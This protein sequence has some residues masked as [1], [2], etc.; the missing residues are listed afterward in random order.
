MTSHEHLENV[1]DRIGQAGVTLN[2]DKCI[3]SQPSVRFLGQ[4]VDA[5]G[6]NPDPEKVRAVRAM[7]EPTNISELRRFLGMANQL[8]K[9]SPSMAET[10]KQLHDFLSNKN[11]WICGDSQRQAFK[12]VKQELC[13]APTLGLYDSRLETLVSAD[14]SS[15]GLGAVLT[16]KQSDGS[17]RPV[18]YASRALTPTEQRYAR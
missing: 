7:K 6:I 5:A 15:Y 2:A 3:F 9:F 14:A 13:S 11:A 12:K 17:H 4:L 16:Q 18:V 8:A 10:T 1:L